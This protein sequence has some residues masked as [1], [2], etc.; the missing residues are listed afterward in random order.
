MIDQRSCRTRRALLGFA[1]QLHA[2][3]TGSCRRTRPSQALN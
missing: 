3:C 1:T 2:F